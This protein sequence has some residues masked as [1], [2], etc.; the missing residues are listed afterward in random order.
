MVMPNEPVRDIMRRTMANLAFVESNANRDG[1]FE[2]TQ[3]I[4]SFLGALAHP[5][6]SMKA[7]FAL[8]S[9]SDAVKQGWPMISKERPTDKDPTSLGDLVRLMRNSFAHGNIT[10]LPSESGEI[11]ALRILNADSKGRRTWGAIVTVEDARSFLECFAATAEK[12]HI[13]Q[14][15]Q[16]QSSA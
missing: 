16:S 13:G 6:E 9:L 7:D 11:R 4:N 15:Q 5:W 3:L 1:L 8:L 2:V 10:F 12:I 14:Y